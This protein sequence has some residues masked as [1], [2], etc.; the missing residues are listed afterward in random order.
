M[1]E[2]FNSDQE[3]APDHIPMM[4]VSFPSAKDPTSCTR[5]PGQSRMVIHTMVNPRWFEQWS[6]IS[7]T[8][9]GEDYE[10]YKMRFANHL[11]DWA[12]VHFPKLKEK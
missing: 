9:R 5:F 3:A 6:N 2:Y 4:Y 1:E 11:F 10:K 12:C 8:E 7:E